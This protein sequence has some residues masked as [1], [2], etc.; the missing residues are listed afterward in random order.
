MPVKS[1]ARA[2]GKRS[3][4]QACNGLPSR[5]RN[6]HPKGHACVSCAFGISPHEPA[7]VAPQAASDCGFCF[8]EDGGS[9]SYRS[10][11]LPAATT[12]KA[13][14]G[15]LTK[16]GDEGHGRHAARPASSHFSAALEKH[17]PQDVMF[18]LCACY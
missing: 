11:F 12:R 17:D 15:P 16:G 10:A 2:L 13:L 1:A 3:R 7:L 8:D 9:A 6:T 5:E 18:S 4:R 14:A